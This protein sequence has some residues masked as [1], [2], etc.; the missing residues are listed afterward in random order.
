MKLS[1]ISED[2]T[3]QQFYDLYALIYLYQTRPDKLITNRL[4]KLGSYILIDLLKQLA[5]VIVIRCSTFSDQS[6]LN[7]RSGSILQKYGLPTEFDFTA[8]EKTAA[9]HLADGRAFKGKLIVG[10]AG[11]QS[12]KKVPFRTTPAVYTQS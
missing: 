3:E 12:F 10:A 7:M 8:D 4:V 1:V 11:R 2:F 6:D 9:V 5:T